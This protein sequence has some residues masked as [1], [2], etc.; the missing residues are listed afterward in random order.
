[1]KDVFLVLK[2]P[3]VS[4]RGKNVHMLERELVMQQSDSVGYTQGKLK[5]GPHKILLTDVHSTYTH[6][7]MEVKRWFSVGKETAVYLDKEMLCDAVKK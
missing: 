1:M 7:N 5:T 3:A 2:Q 4:K 6:Q